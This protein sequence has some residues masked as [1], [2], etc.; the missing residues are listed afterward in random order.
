MTHLHSLVSIQVLA[1]N[2]GT[3][4]CGD[5]EHWYSVTGLQPFTGQ[6][7]CLLI[8]H[9]LINVNIIYNYMMHISNITKAMTVMTISAWSSAI[10]HPAQSPYDPSSKCFLSSLI[11]MSNSQH[12][13]RR[14]VLYKVVFIVPLYL[15][16]VSV[17]VE[18]VSLIP[19]PGILLSVL[20]MLLLMH[21]VFVVLLVQVV[22]LYMCIDIWS[23]CQKTFIALLWY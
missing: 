16:N 6:Y 17:F 18:Y 23:E 1:K 19:L 21:V 22:L 8:Q 9:A 13:K 2:S 15:V 7:F 10:S 14:G 5:I 3:D 4:L 20:L 12:F 11:G